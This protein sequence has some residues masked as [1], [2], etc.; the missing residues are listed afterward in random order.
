MSPEMSAALVHTFTN[1][2][3]LPENREKFSTLG[4]VPMPSKSK[5]L[6]TLRKIFPG[7]RFQCMTVNKIKSVQLFYRQARSGEAPICN[8]EIPANGSEEGACQ[9]LLCAAFRGLGG[10]AKWD[11][12]WPGRYVIEPIKDFQGPETMLPVELDPEVPINVEKLGQT[13][14]DAQNGTITGPEAQAQI[15]QVI[16]EATTPG[17]SETP[18]LEA[19][20]KAPRKPRAKVV[21]D[22]AAPKAPRKAKVK[23]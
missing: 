19:K 9:A 14:A 21:K 3:P 12:K 18:A 17:A 16:Q 2:E 10:E 20:V 7:A 4:L 8:V 22:P 13:L 23:P 15:E 1:Q 5:T 11:P 6:R